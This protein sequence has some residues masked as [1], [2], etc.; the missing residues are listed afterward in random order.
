MVRM[1]VHKSTSAV[2]I[3][4]PKRESSDQWPNHIILS[5][6]L[7]LPD[8]GA[9]QGP[10]SIA[11]SQNSGEVSNTYLSLGFIVFLQ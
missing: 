10:L 8:L 9:D 11:I 2:I 6:V 7:V 4:Y 3:F 5:R 1:L